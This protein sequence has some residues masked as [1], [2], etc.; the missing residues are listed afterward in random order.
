MC[1]TAFNSITTAQFKAELKSNNQLQTEKQ[2]QMEEQEIHDR[3]CYFAQEDKRK[4]SQN[5]FRRSRQVKLTGVVTQSAITITGNTGKIQADHEVA[6]LGS[7]YYGSSGIAGAGSNFKLS[8]SKVVAS[9]KRQ[10]AISASVDTSKLNPDSSQ[11]S[12]RNRA[13]QNVNRTESGGLGFNIFD[14]LHLTDR[15]G[16][17]AESGQ[18]QGVQGGQQLKLEDTTAPERHGSQQM[19]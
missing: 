14:S 4:E 8:P 3:E 17:Q 18:G 7:S 12:P 9:P 1:S 10:S 11:N 5:E 2:L 6:S 19:I 15:V 16:T 13:K